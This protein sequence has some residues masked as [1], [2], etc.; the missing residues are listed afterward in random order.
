MKKIKEMEGRSILLK[1]END[2]VF[3][4]NQKAEKTGEIRLFSLQKNGE[5]K[6]LY[7]T[8]GVLYDD[9]PAQYTHYLKSK[10][11]QIDAARQRI[12]FVKYRRKPGFG[13]LPFT[14]V[15][16][17]YCGKILFEILF[18]EEIE[19]ESIQFFKNGDLLFFGQYNKWVGTNK[20]RSYCCVKRVSTDGEVKWEKVQEFGKNS[21]MKYHEWT[22][23]E[24]EWDQ[25]TRGEWENIYLTADDK[26]L[27]AVKQSRGWIDYK[28][29]Q[30]DRDFCKDL[31]AK[32]LKSG[33]FSTNSNVTLC[34]EGFDIVET[35]ISEEKVQIV[36]NAYDCLGDQIDE[37]VIQ[38]KNRPNCMDV[39]HDGVLMTFDKKIIYRN[40]ED[41]SIVVNKMV[42]D[43][44]TV[45]HRFADKLTCFMFE[46]DGGIELATRIRVLTENGGCEEVLDHDNAG[47]IQLVNGHDFIICL[48]IDIM[49]WMSE[50]YYIEA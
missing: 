22:Y 9:T 35:L 41:Y 28:I 25:M 37:K 43:V 38:W 47:Y 11:H 2:S 30:N 27:L 13:Y 23:S 12:V 24:N 48:W 5:M 33:A 31:R 26:I 36:R 39:E 32:K 19:P 45:K 4:L 17:D 50:F 49:N 14:I 20:E 6:E 3:I 10:V 8:D 46:N 16:L 29:Y 18:E 40:F 34:G 21:D 1:G 44:E 7:C 15:G 42:Q